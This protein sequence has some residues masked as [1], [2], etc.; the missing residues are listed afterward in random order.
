MI[1]DNRQTAR[2]RAAPML[3]ALPEEPSL[4]EIFKKGGSLTSIL[5]RYDVRKREQA[6]RMAQYLERVQGTLLD[7]AKQKET[8][9]DPRKAW[10]AATFTRNTTSGSITAEATGSGTGL[11]VTV[12]AN[13]FELRSG[14]DAPP[15]GW[16]SALPGT[17]I[18]DTNLY[19]YG[20]PSVIRVSGTGTVRIQVLPASTYGFFP[21]DKNVEFSSHQ[22]VAKVG[23]DYLVFLRAEIPADG[24]DVSAV[25]IPIGQV[26]V[27]L[28][29]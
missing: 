23:S 19:R 26:Y 27:E 22:C 21:T 6:T 5:E 8:S 2:L 7:L 29:T 16:L 1:T 12:A 18:A 28:L 14:G 15:A 11:G 20:Y 4:F 24:E 17:V 3:P 13:V 25:Q 10:Y 9:G